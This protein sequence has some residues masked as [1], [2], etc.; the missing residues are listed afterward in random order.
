MFQF[1]KRL[2]NK[3]KSKTYI[4][5]V[6]KLKSNYSKIFISDT[7]YKQIEFLTGDYKQLIDKIEI[8]RLYMSSK[9]LEGLSSLYIDLR[10]IHIQDLITIKGRY[11]NKKEFNKLLETILAYLYSLESLETIKFPSP[12]EKRTLLSTNRMSNQLYLLIDVLSN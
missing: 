6:I 11:I 7:Q 3:S 4:N 12:E 2:F 9:N 1:I 5:K 10:T 8:F